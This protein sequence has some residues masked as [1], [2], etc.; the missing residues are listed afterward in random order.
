MDQIKFKLVGETP[1][2]MHN[3][4]LANPLDNYSQEISKK[5]GKRKKTLEDIWELARI[6]WEGGL[7]LYDGEIKIPMRVVNKC[8]ERG[9]TKQKNG[10]LWKS[11]CFI[12]D[13]FCPLNYPGQKINVQANSDIPN[14]E[15][16][17]YFKKHMFQ[18]M[19]RIGQATLLRTRPMF[20]DWS[21]E[22]TVIFDGSVINRET[23]IQAA[24]DAGHLVGLCDWRMEKG[25]QYG[26][27]SIEVVD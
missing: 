2:L 27:F 23:L 18:S 19:V 14:P 10:M 22:T 5:S 9:A 12:K 6:E 7:Y 17:K 16:D 8:F 11:G 4:R 3:N 20:E 26:R 25:G 21:F 15:L 13:D 24:I 1:L